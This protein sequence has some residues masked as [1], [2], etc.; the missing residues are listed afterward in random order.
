MEKRFKNIRE[1]WKPKIYEGDMGCDW[2]DAHNHCWRCGKKTPDNLVILCNSC[3]KEAPDF[4]QTDKM[5]NWIKN[6]STTFYAEFLS[7][8]VKKEYEDMTGENL[9]DKF[10]SLIDNKFTETDIL[11]VVKKHMHKI[12]FHGGNVS[13]STYACLLENVIEELEQKN[14][15]ALDINEYNQ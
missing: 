5:W 7:K 12:G 6:T 13:Y 4:N 14:K 15:I 2:A 1:Y 3:H 11:N 10:K 9:F 8:R